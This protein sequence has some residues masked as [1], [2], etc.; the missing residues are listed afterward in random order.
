MSSKMTEPGGCDMKIG[1]C[2]TTSFTFARYSPQA[3]NSF[4]LLVNGRVTLQEGLIHLSQI[5]MRKIK[6]AMKNSIL[7]TDGLTIRSID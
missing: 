1:A 6:K 7:M 4:Q 3:G 2:T 5:E